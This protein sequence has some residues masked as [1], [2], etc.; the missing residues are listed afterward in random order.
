MVSLLIA[1]AILAK[2]DGKAMEH[3]IAVEKELERLFDFSF[4]Y[5]TQEELD[6]E[7]MIARKMRQTM[8]RKTQ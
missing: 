8:T 5:R 6:E 4:E 1:E 3:F 7:Q 2:K